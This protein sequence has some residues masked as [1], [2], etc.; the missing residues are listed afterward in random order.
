MKL[1]PAVWVGKDFDIPVE[2]VDGPYVLQGQRYWMVQDPRYPGE[3][4]G[5]LEIELRQDKDCKPSPPR[6]TIEE[7]L[8]AVSDFFGV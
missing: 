8:Q 4:T 1:G 3:Q 2:I 7:L 5:L 6:S